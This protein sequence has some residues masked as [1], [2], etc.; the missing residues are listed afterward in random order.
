MG[1]FNNYGVHG[2]VMGHDMIILEHHEPDKRKRRICRCGCRK[3]AT[4]IQFC[5]GV[6]MNSG[7]EKSIYAFVEKIENYKHQEKI[8]REKL[9]KLLGLKNEN[10]N[11]R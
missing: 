8:K 3:K 10:T 5:N 7:C 9:Y 4:H 1:N 2:S 6:A 11:K